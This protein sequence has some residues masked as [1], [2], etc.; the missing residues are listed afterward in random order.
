[1]NFEIEFENISIQTTQF[2][3][4]INDNISSIKSVSFEKDKW[5]G[6]DGIWF[7]I[8][9]TDMSYGFD[10]FYPFQKCNERK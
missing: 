3:C 9:F 4:I 8:Q 5:F 1:M 10:S 2:I 6:G 7:F